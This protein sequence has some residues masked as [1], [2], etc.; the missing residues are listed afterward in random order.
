MNLVE[1]SHMSLLLTT[2]RGGCPSTKCTRRT[3]E[4]TC[5]G[6]K[7]LAFCRLERAFVSWL[8]LV[9]CVDAKTAPY[10]EAKGPRFE[11]CYRWDKMNKKLEKRQVMAEKAEW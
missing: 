8:I 9:L 5:E 6:E 4:R 10:P 11:S 3:M 1:H 7:V 2:M